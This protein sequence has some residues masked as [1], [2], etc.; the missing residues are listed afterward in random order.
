MK[1]IT[2][3][4]C[5][6]Y[7]L[8]VNVN[9]IG[10]ILLY[11]NLPVYAQ[12]NNNLP[13]SSCIDESISEN[14]NGEL[15]YNIEYAKTQCKDIILNIA[16]KKDSQP[17]AFKNQE[18]EWE[19]LC[20]KLAEILKKQINHDFGKNVVKDI[21][22]INVY[23]YKNRYSKVA[24]KEADLECG[25]NT[26]RKD[27]D[28]DTN[29]DT[30]QDAD[31]DTKPKVTF[32]DIFFTSGIRLLIRKENKNEFEEYILSKNKKERQISVVENSTT[33]EKIK[34]YYGDITTEKKNK[35]EALISLI[36]G[37]VLAW[38]TDS[39][40]I[41]SLLKRGLLFKLD[42]DIDFD[43]SK[44]YIYP[45]NHFLS[46]EHYGLVVHIDN[47][48]W[49]RYINIFLS[50]PDVK[51]EIRKETKKFDDPEKL[52]EQHNQNKVTRNFLVFV[53]VLLLILLGV[54][55]I[56]LFNKKDS[57]VKFE[58]DNRIEKAFYLVSIPIKNEGDFDYN[59]PYR[60]L[61]QMQEQGKHED[62]IFF[63]VER[64][65]TEDNE[66]IIA[67]FKLSTNN[68]KE[69]FIQEF[70]ASLNSKDSRN[71]WKVPEPLKAAAYGVGL[72][73]L[74]DSIESGLKGLFK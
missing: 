57:P 61:K 54:I 5:Q 35:S 63:C 9:I 69:T 45:E 14:E 8:I 16:V 56:Y 71:K 12:T 34:D 65:E 44:Y 66:R 1:L 58:T 7:L 67:K 38:A 30:D 28:Q 26:I 24:Q 2:N 25:G 11:F 52:Y 22:Y 40:F 3:T 64:D 49:K 51:K 20:I 39:I 27:T 42:L 15:E 33:V 47:K 60:T 17:F 10:I 32:S 46:Y 13:L 6:L 55:L 4:V 41:E 48:N 53:I 37:T 19:G 31:Q 72:R 29:Q 21:E 73:K 50:Q 18:N 59:A 70:Y 43:L 68:N 74:V 62:I 23:S 36:R